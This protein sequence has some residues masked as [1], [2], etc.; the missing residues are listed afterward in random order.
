MILAALLLLQTPT[1]PPTPA[2]ALDNPI[3]KLV[4]SPGLRVTMT[5]QDT[6]RLSTT[7][8]DSLGKAV[9]NMQV[10][11]VGQGAYFEAKVDPDGLIH[12]GSTGSFTVIVSARVPGGRAV[13]EVV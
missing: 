5:A 11:Y 10:S 8:V 13:R 6:L 3:A 9:P 2:V 12:S 1:Q 7:G 4:V